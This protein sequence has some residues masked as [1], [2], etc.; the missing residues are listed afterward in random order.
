MRCRESP[1]SVDPYARSVNG[2]ES[3]GD[4]DLILITQRSR[5]QIPPAT[6]SLKGLRSRTVALFLFPSKSHLTTATV[7][8]RKAEEGQICENGAPVLLVLACLFVVL[9]ATAR[10]QEPASNFWVY[11]PGKKSWGTYTSAA[12]PSERLVMDVWMVGYVTGFGA[13]G[14]AFGVKLAETDSGAIRGM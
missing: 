8:A 10:S 12:D 7:P 11:G 14:F 6:K 9:G 1:N 4:R 3:A 5:V 13:G 2:V